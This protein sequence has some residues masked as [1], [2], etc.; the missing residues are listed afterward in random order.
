MKTYWVYM[1]RCS[2]GSFYVGVTN[3]L[4]LRVNQHEFGF[5]AF[6]D[7]RAT[8]RDDFAAL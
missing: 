8:I 7:W 5:D 4:E 1:L 6:Q 3:D 2:D